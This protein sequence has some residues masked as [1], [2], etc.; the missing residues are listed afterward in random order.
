MKASR[1]FGLTF[2]AAFTVSALQA[3]AFVDKD[4]DGMDDIWEAHYG[5][6]TT[7]SADSSEHPEADPD[8]DDWSNLKESLAGTDP[9][10]NEEPEGL[11]KTHLAKNPSLSGVFTVSWTATPGKYYTLW[12]S[13]D[14]QTWTQV[15]LPMV[16]DGTP[17][18][19]AVSSSGSSLFW[20]T[21]VADEDSDGD[22]LSDFEEWLLATDPHNSDSDGDGI[23]DAGEVEQGKNPNDPNDTPT[24]DWFTMVGDKPVNEEKSETRLFIIKKGETRVFVIGSQSDEFPAYTGNSS[25]FNDTLEWTIAP[26]SGAA[27][28]SSINVNDRH[29]DWIADYVTGVTLNGKSPVQI[30]KVKVIQAPVDSDIVVT[31]TLKGTNISD[32]SLPSSLIVGVLQIKIVPDDDMVGVVGDMISSNKGTG[33]QRHFVT[34]KVTSEISATHVNLKVQGLEEAWI[35]AGNPNQLVEWVPGVGESDSGTPP[36]VLKWRVKRDAA[37]KNPVKIRT[38]EKYGHEEAA[39]LNVWVVWADLKS[40]TAYEN[41]GFNLGETASSYSGNPFSEGGWRF[42]F[43]IKPTSITSATDDRPALDGNKQTPVPGASNPYFANSGWIADSAAKK[44]DVSRQLENTILNLNLIPKANFPDHAIYANQPKKKDV[45]V[46]YPS[47]AAEGNDDPLALVDENDDPYNANTANGLTH[48]VGELASYDNPN[49]SIP[50]SAGVSGSAFTN[51]ANFR[52]FARL[53]IASSSPASGATTW[54]RI[55]NYKEWH[56]VLAAIYGSLDNQATYFWKDSGS[57]SAEGIFEIPN[58]E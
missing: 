18:E 29:E 23:S 48:D 49:F 53:E 54:F 40:T 30:E 57:E 11:L 14:L 38:I 20:R 37:E 31:V 39:K 22:G 28:T 5:F 25:T 36:D 34:P 21:S 26:S 16:G 13:S 58:V 24:A 2:I 15:G 43:S 27:I 1:K 3:G 33:G 4:N 41:V 51:L 19:I 56:H 45:P 9:L 47:N 50:N 10:S 55:S 46:P 35:T 17:I 12:A 7:G 52:E 44:W 42:V 8:G 6:S 32:G